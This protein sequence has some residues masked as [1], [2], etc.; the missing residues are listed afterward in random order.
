MNVEILCTPGNSAAKCILQAGEHITAEGGS[1]IAMS[2]NMEIETTTHQKGKGGILKGLKRMFA[3]ENFFLNHYTADSHGGEVLLSTTLAGDMQV[4]ELDNEKLIVQSGSFVACEPTI[5]IDMGWEGFKNL[6]SKES[7][8]WLHM[9]GSGKVIFNSFGAI[10]P[11]EVKD[12]YIVDTGHIVAFEETLNFSL[13]KAGKS[14]FSSFL[15]GE[16]LVCKFKGQGTVW[17]Q[18]HNPASFGWS[19]GPLLPSRKA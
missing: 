16:G 3:G 6:F 10:Y 17:C 9:K 13:S 5:D 15:G 8:F 7:L 4:H 19:I 2:G 12:E 14:W 11:I 18:S 1:M